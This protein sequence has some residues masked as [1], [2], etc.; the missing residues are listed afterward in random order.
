ML[1]KDVDSIISESN[2]L[3]S[4]G[5]LIEQI[6]DRV[7]VAT[8]SRTINTSNIEEAT[9]TSNKLS[10]TTTRVQSPNSITNFYLFTKKIRNFSPQYPFEIIFSFRDRINIALSSHIIFIQN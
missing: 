9:T 7:A 3:I 5:I 4:I 10:V 8:S 1:V 2:S 6:N